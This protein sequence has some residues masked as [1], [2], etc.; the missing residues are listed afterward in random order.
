MIR[1]AIVLL[2]CLTN[3]D[4]QSILLS[5][6]RALRLPDAGRT[7]PDALEIS[8]TCYSLR[9]SY[10]RH[11][12]VLLYLPVPPSDRAIST[13]V[14]SGTGNPCDASAPPDTRRLTRPYVDDYNDMASLSSTGGEGSNG[15]AKIQHLTEY[16]K[17]KVFLHPVGGATS[18]WNH[19]PRIL[20][21][22]I[23]TQPMIPCTL[24]GLLHFP[25]N[26]AT[27]L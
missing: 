23:P 11:L 6:G 22:R 12:C 21:T 24:S 2:I 25:S 26:C 15:M 9:C 5:L 27:S 17:L 16:M 4:S 1:H 3:D 18:Q 20:I 13:C 8:I 7:K 10:Y 19:F 14:Q